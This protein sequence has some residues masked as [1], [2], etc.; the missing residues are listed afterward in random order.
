[1]TK[2]EENKIIDQAVHTN[3]QLI[4]FHVTKSEIKLPQNTLPT[5][6]ALYQYGLRSAYAGEV[7][8]FNWHLMRLQNLFIILS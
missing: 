1:M 2:S 8:I 3:F 5:S 4:L 7:P 6:D